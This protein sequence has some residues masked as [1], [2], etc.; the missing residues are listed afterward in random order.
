MYVCAPS[1]ICLMVFLDTL[2]WSQFILPFLKSNFRFR[3]KKYDYFPFKNPISRILTSDH[4]LLFSYVQIKREISTMSEAPQCSTTI[5]GWKLFWLLISLPFMC[6]FFHICNQLLFGSR[7]RIHR[8]N[9]LFSYVGKIFVQYVI[10]VNMDRNV[11]NDD[12]CTLFLFRKESCRK[13]YF[14]KYFIKM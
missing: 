6:I 8:E 5:R 1:S 2:L 10:S 3:L 14:L 4:L 12:F 9:A 13:C 7:K 11:I